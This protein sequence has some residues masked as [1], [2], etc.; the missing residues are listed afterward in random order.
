MNNKGLVARAACDVE[1]VAKLHL[2]VPPFDKLAVLLN[3]VLGGVPVLRALDVRMMTFEVEGR[4]STVV[5]S[6]V[7]NEHVTVRSTV[8]VLFVSG[9]D[10]NAIAKAVAYKRIEF[11]DT[12]AATWV[13]QE[14]L[15]GL[16]SEDGHRIF[17][18]KGSED[19]FLYTRVA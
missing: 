6:L 1:D 8:F 14:K 10:I 18:Q 9:N 16:K 12:H 13:C 19:A 4:S 11:F 17:I 7:F 5:S 2:I 15:V 3:V